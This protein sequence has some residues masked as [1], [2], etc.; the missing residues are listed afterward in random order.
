MAWKCNRNYGIVQGIFRVYDQSRWLR[1]AAA[2]RRTT[3]NQRFFKAIHMNY[4]QGS[5]GR[6]FLLRFVKGDDL[7]EELQ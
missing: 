6:V 1:H 3:G 5:F 4:Q 7:L 2:R